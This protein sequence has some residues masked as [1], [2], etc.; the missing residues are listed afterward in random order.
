MLPFVWST[1]MPPGTV[2]HGE[3]VAFVP[4]STG[5]GRPKFKPPSVDL[6]T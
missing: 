1:V 2:L 5:T 3:S 6:V 4:C